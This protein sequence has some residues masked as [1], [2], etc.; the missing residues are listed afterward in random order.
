MKRVFEGEVLDFRNQ[1]GRMWL[2]PDGSKRSVVLPTAFV[3]D[4]GGQRIRVTVEEIDTHN[5]LTGKCP[6]CNAHDVELFNGPDGLECDGCIKRW[7]AQE[8]GG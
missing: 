5:P 6:M 3:K 8:M 4:M 7:K 1:G 2:R